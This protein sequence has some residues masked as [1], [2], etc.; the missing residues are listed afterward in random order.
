MLNKTL[1]LN[2]K[3]VKCQL[4]TSYQKSL[5]C[6][7]LFPSI[8]YSTI[9]LLFNSIFNNMITIQL[10]IQQYDYYTTLYSTI[11]LLFNSIFN[12][13]ITIQL[14]IQQYDYYTTLY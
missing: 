14:Y 4:S 1:G 5:R 8:L 7:M 9:W 3:E 10:Y 12:N 2:I 13:M 11:W 6:F